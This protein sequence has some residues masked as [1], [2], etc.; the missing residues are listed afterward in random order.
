MPPGYGTVWPAPAEM[1]VTLSWCADETA[2]PVAVKGSSIAW[3][4]FGGKTFNWAAVVGLQA[5]VG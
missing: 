3:V 5:D 1:A 4:W 2:H